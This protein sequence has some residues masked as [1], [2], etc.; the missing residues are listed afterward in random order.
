MIWWYLEEVMQPQ[1]LDVLQNR[2][3]IIVWNF[4][5]QVAYADLVAA[6]SLAAA[7]EKGLVSMAA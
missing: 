2:V 1:L 4:L 5:D 7:R 3:M 6:G